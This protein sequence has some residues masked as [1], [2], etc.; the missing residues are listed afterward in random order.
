MP[1]PR[2]SPDGASATLSPR[3][4]PLKPHQGE[5]CDRQIYLDGHIRAAR[6][7]ENPVFIRESINMW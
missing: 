4:V 3:G 6:G 1:S 5:R 2:S 7:S